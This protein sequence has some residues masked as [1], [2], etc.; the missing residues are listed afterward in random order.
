[1]I[2]EASQANPTTTTTLPR[3]RGSLCCW[4]LICRRLHRL[5][6]ASVCACLACKALMPVSHGRILRAITFALQCSRYAGA[7][8]WHAC[9]DHHPAAVAMQLPQPRQ[10]RASQRPVGRHRGNDS[11]AYSRPVPTPDRSR[12]GAGAAQGGALHAQPVVAL[13]G[14]HGRERRARVRRLTASSRRVPAA[15]RATAR[16]AAD[17][18]LCTQVRTLARLAEH[19]HLLQ[20]QSRL[21]TQQDCTAPH[22]A[23]TDAR[24]EFALPIQRP[25]PRSRR[26]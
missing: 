2:C 3:A 19:Q 6:C 22:C 16:F 9:A 4:R 7:E 8:L 13:H 24:L 18:N 12:R 15:A 1:M 10:L 17:G 20:T 26:F 5:V 11:S 21:D 14:H 23:H 25:R